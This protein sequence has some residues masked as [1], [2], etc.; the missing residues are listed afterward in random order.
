MALSF[1]S[2]LWCV[3]NSSQ[4]LTLTVCV[5]VLSWLQPN[6]AINIHNNKY[7]ALITDYFCVAE[8]KWLRGDFSAEEG[9]G[10]THTHL[11]SKQFPK[12][13]GPIMEELYPA[14]FNWG[15]LGS[16]SWC[17]NRAGGPIWVAQLG[18]RRCPA[19][20]FIQEPVIMGIILKACS[21][22]LGSGFAEPRGREWRETLSACA[23]QGWDIAFVNTR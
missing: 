15:S 9:F 22:A 16:P 3:F 4:K 6:P 13:G 23:T 14:P 10:D 7:K 18:G 11:L 17:G 21:T 5:S 2:P 1:I 20:Q 19:L 12:P 8:R